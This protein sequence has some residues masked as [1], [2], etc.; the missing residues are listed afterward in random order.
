[1]I[2][3]LLHLADAKD[4]E[5]L[6]LEFV[7]LLGVTCSA[8]PALFA[9]IITYAAFNVPRLSHYRA[10][11]FITANAAMKTMAGL[12]RETYPLWPQ[13]SEEW[14]WQFRLNAILERRGFLKIN[15]QDLENLNRQAKAHVSSKSARKGKQHEK[16]HGKKSKHR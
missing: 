1:L 11:L 7:G 8:Q 12:V 4:S 10:M 14:E 6:I 2:K 16:G 13:L 5:Q 9:G 3:E 15:D